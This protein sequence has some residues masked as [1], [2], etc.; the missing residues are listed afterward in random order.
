VLTKNL[1]HR[2]GHQSVLDSSYTNFLAMHPLTFTEVL[3]PLEVD[4][5]LHITESKFWLL[6]CIEFQKTLYM[7]QQLC[8]SAS[9]WWA[10]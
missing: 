3:D 4:N 1:M 10:N 9:A 7:A 2:R 5:W 8:G 6:H